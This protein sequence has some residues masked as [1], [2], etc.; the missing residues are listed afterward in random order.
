MSE[1][2]ALFRRLIRENGPISLAQYMAES[3]ARYYNSRDPLGDAGDFIT[4]PE[5]SQM[6]GELVGLW[7]V[8]LWSQ[9][10]SPERVHYIEL[11]PGRGTLAQ[12]AL[13]S[14]AR[15]GFEPEVH[16]VE[17]SEA[18]RAMQR[19]RVPG[20]KHH[21]DL[22]S[23]PDDAPLMIVANEFFDALPIHQL[24]RLEA[25]WRER[26]VGLD[27]DELVFVA[28]DKPMDAAVPES[29][30]DA[31]VG[32]LIESCP[33]ASTAAGEI[34][35]RL[36]AQGGA[37]LIVDYGSLEAR[38]GSTLQAVRAHKKVSALAHP[39]EADLTAHVDF[40]MLRDVAASKGAHVL[41]TSTQGNWLR[42]MG[43]DAR[44]AMLKQQSPEN[45]ETLQR[46]RDRLVEDDQMG[47]LF[48]VLGLTGGGRPKG[49]IG[50]D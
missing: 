36:S 41:G 47:T 40:E 13:R 1:N 26:M 3:N 50:L 49:A 30:R 38:T 27:G 43:I 24:V 14:G 11:G 35:R 7:L 15:F 19:Q 18:L 20:A 46:Q 31:D 29:L 22:S 8:D 23:L 16:F 17:G 42:A 2:A 4:A 21:Q 5:I 10:G 9:D 48:K 45:A 39:G 6:F 37:A 12:D 33:A 34:A 25:G 28:G 44:L 32:T